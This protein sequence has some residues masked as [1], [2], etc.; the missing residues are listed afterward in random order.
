MNAESIFVG[1]DVS[2]GRLDVATTAGSEFFVSNDD[3]GLVEL[4]NQLQTSSCALIVLEATG[5]FEIAAVSAI[6]AAGLPVVVANPRQTRDF[7]RATGQLA[8]TDSIDARG[9]A[10]FAERVKPDVRALPSDAVRLLDATLTRRRQLVDMITAEKNR[11][12]FAPA[13]LKKN[14]GKHIKWLQRELDGVDSHLDA[15]IKNSPVWRAKDDLLRTVPGVGPVLSRTLIA[16]LPELGR[17]TRKQVAALVGVAPLARDSGT[18]R[19]KR[20]IFGGRTSV[21]SALYMGALVGTRHNPVIRTF[22]RRLI[23][24]GKLPK[25]ALVACMRKLL[26][27]LNAMLKSNSSWRPNNA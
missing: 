5:G 20:M 6:A 4:I 2:K 17:L 13:P 11:L 24:A 12:G 23:A 3:A 21:R 16:E 7:A 9:L 10:L 14:I 1:I 18:F 15:A 22:Y 8:K 25:V 19:G 27:I 26:I